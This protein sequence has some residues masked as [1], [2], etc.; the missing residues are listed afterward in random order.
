ME[1]ALK[2]LV[3]VTE[4]LWKWRGYPIHILSAFRGWVPAGDVYQML[5]S[6]RK[7]PEPHTLA[8]LALVKRDATY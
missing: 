8:R 5:Q 4:T 3:K 7:D 6:R 2:I 1:L